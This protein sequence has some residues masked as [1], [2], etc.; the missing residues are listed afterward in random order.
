MDL[1]TA[2]ARVGQA[3]E[4]MTEA[5]HRQVF[6]EVVIVEAAGRS[7]NV[8]F[9]T[10]PRREQFMRDLADQTI[11]LRRELPAGRSEDP[12]EFGFTREGEGEHFDAYICLGPKVYLFCNNTEKSM[13]EVTQDP[14]WLEA[15]QK[16]LNACQAFAAD[17]LRIESA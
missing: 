2:I 12:G 5:Y 15:Q 11:R 9:Y 10:G 4:Q 14:R 16:F 13:H 7:P 8:L 6:D 17:P 3:L 1:E